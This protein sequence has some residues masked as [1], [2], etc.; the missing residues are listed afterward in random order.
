MK[1]ANS[2]LLSGAEERL[3][4]VPSQAAARTIAVQ[5]H[6]NGKGLMAAAPWSGAISQ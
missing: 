2:K 6:V 1:L 5:S 3:P 4:I